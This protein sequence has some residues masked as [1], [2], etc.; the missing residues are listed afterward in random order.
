MKKNILKIVALSIVTAVIALGP[1]PGLAQEKKKDEP[2]AEK[3][4]TPK[5]GKK[6]KRD[7]LPGRGKVDAIDKTAKTVKVG[8]RVLHVTS[9][10]RIRKNN[11]AATLDDGVVGE[12]IG[13]FAR[14]VDGKLM[15]VSIR[16]G[17]APEGAAKGEKKD[18]EKKEKKKKQE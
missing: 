17:A 1:T 13:F 7:G 15:A 12:E 3:K 6:G 9:E 10:T 2:K 11:Q 5:E 4:D 16:F 8:E 14:E 18:G